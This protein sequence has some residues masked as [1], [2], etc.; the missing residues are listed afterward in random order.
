MR[1]DFFKQALEIVH[2]PYILANMI[3]ARMK[4]LRNGKRPLVESV[5]TLSLE[6]VAMREIIEG[7]LTYVLGD[8]VVLDEI[9]GLKKTLPHWRYEAD[10]PTLADDFHDGS[11]DPVQSVPASAIGAARKEPRSIPS[12][13]LCASPEPRREPAGTTH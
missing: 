6:D 1:D 13:N 2:D 11:P 5:E 7:Q 10:P 4:M 8:L 12:K 9:A 3:L